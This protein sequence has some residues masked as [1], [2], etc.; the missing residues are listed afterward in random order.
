MRNYKWWTE[1]EEEFLRNNW[2]NIP[3]DILES[4]L[5]RKFTAIKEKAHK[6]N[7]PHRW[8]DIKQEWTKEDIKYLKENWE[9]ASLEE[10]IKVLKRKETSIKQKAHILNLPRRIIH[11]KKSFRFISKIDGKSYSVHKRRGYLITIIKKKQIP[12]HR[13]E[14]EKIVG[15]K[16][17]PNEKIHHKNGIKDDNRPENLM[18]YESQKRHAHIDTERA[19]IAEQ[20]IKEKKHGGRI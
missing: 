18:L 11:G 1:E 16:L 17:K 5:Q 12:M 6:M 4:K 10:L 2:M 20:F 14:M 19:E 15:R 8:A 3:Q 13:I 9:W 7:F